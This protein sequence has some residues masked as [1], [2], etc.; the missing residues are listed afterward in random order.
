MRGQ[1]SND[2]GK[3]QQRYPRA[4]LACSAVAYT[5]STPILLPRSA[6]Y[7]TA[8]ATC[9]V[10][11][12]SGMGKAREELTVK[13]FGRYLCVGA[14]DAESERASEVCCGVAVPASLLP[15]FLSSFLPSTRVGIFIGLGCFYY[16]FRFFLIFLC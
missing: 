4:S 16:S 2:E 6:V 9:Y 14:R 8:T 5:A 12:R 1:W 15:P 10:V 7:N 3:Q 11:I 13:L